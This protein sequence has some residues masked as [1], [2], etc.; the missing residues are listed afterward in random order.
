MK[1]IVT[2]LAVAALCICAWAADNA[3]IAPQSNA[4][5]K[6]QATSLGPEAITIPQMLSYQGK[7]TDTLG[8]PVADTTYNCAFELYTVPSG[9]TPF[10]SESQVVRTKGGLFSVLL[11]ST[12]PIS[13]IP[14]AG[15]VYL[16]MAFGGPSGLTPRLR[17]VS[18]AYAY[19][20][21][22]ANYALAGGT[23]ENAWVRGGDSVLYTA[24]KLG[25]AR[26]GA[27]NKL[28]GDS[29]CTHVN[30]GIACTTGASD[31]VRWHATVGGGLGNVAYR[32][33][34]TVAGG[35]RGAAL[36]TYSTVG[37]GRDN[38]AG[39]MDATVG[40][41]FWNRADGGS[42]TIAGGY[43]NIASD[44]YATIAGGSDNVAGG[45]YSFVGGGSCDTTTGNYSTVD[46]GLHNVASS[47]GAAVLGGGLNR[48]SGQYASVSGGRF[49]VASGS[50]SA[51]CGGYADTSA[52]NYSFTATGYSKVP[53]GYDYSVAVN[54]QT[55]T[56]S[57]QLRCGTL[58]KTGGSFTIDHP[59]D[60]YGKILNHY[61]VES[62]DMSNLYSGSVVL[63]A[64]GRGEVRLPDYFDALNRSPRV[65]LTGVGTS[66][67]FVAED[68]SGN[69]F[70]VGGKPGAKVY[71][72]VTGDRKDVS[73]EAIRRMMPVE[74]PKTGPLAGKML[75][76]DFLVGC[77]DQLVREGKA[78]G[79]DFRTAAGRQRYDLMKQ[80]LREV[81]K[82]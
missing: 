77:M 52:A 43:D 35:R 36:G 27:D 73:A 78:Q 13:S 7:V 4:S 59:L 81:G 54:G 49:S 23:P 26:G 47:E 11:G 80:H 53:T 82:Q 40:G 32:D 46:G 9:G 76:D 28:W 25:I 5:H 30:F 1:T 38:V 72:Q 18:A 34:S 31:N 2:V 24:H 29:A 55:A 67:V 20:A 65:Q 48:A 44:I 74:Q 68:I 45:Q 51:A 15:A 16:A 66:D 17:I 8:Q 22:T 63:D 71:W 50:Y 57:G 6:P 12:T 60:P 14:D 70:A 64:A 79:I 3:V 39:G 10:W 42:A 21:D 62:P 61:F 56:A 58:S 41:G 75:D 37:G 69:R 19:K 33:Y